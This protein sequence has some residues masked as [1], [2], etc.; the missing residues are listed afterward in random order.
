MESRPTP[1]SPSQRPHVAWRRGAA[2][3]AGLLAGALFV[4]A[5]AGDLGLPIIDVT[6]LS[7]A[8]KP[9][10][11]KT[12]MFDV[13][14]T[15]ILNEPAL[16]VCVATCEPFA[17]TVTLPTPLPVESVTMPETIRSCA[18]PDWQMNKTADSRV[19]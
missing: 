3:S 1:E 13:A 2:I 6:P 10:E 15:D 19:E 7:R 16:L 4:G 8:E 17:V 9:T 18:K 12:R 11:V 5:H 14:G